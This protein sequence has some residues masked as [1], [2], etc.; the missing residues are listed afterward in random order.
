MTRAG[1]VF[2]LPFLGGL[3]M[4][5]WC[6][7]EPV[8]WNGRG[9]DDTWSNESN[10]IDGALPANNGTSDVL[11]VGNEGLTPLVDVDWSINSLAFDGLARTFTINGFPL[12][13]G[14]GGIVNNSDRPQIVNSPINLS[15]AQTWDAAGGR[16]SFG[17]AINNQGHAMTVGG[18]FDTAIRSTISNGGGLIKN[19]SGT[20]TLG[21]GAGDTFAN[22]YSGVTSV[23]GGGLLLNKAAG[24]ITIPGDLIVN[25]GMVITTASG[26]ISTSSNVTLNGGS[27]HFG[28]SNT[29]GTFTGNGSSYTSSDQTLTLTS[30][31][32]YVLTLRQ[33]G[34]YPNEF[35]K[36]TGASGG[37][38]FV[39]YTGFISAGIPGLDLGA[40]D[41]VINTQGSLFIG[42][43][44]VVAGGGGIIKTG[45]DTLYIS[46]P[47]AADNTYAGGTTINEGTI[48]VYD[49]GCLGN[50]VAPLTLNGGRLLV[51]S[52][53]AV[54][55]NRPVSI[56]AAGGTFDGGG[57][58]TLSAGRTGH[59]GL[60]GS[61]PITKNGTGT[62]TLGDPNEA[63]NRVPNTYNGT[64]TVN[65]GTL[66]L[67]NDPFLALAGGSINVLNSGSLDLDRISASNSDILF[68]SY[69]SL[70][71]FSS[72][73]VH[74]FTLLK[75]A[76]LLGNT[77]IL[78]AFTLGSGVNPSAVVYFKDGDGGITLLDNGPDPST[79][80]LSIDLGNVQ[81][82]FDVADNLPATD[83][84]INSVISNGGVRKIGPGTL[85]LIGVNDY[86]GGTAI[87]GGTVLIAA[88]SGLGEAGSPLTLDAGVLRASS[89]FVL[90]HP[91]TSN[92]GG[93]NV[94]AG[95]TL[96]VVPVVEGRALTKLGSGTLVL[97]N[98]T[99]ND[100]L[101]IDEGTVAMAGRKA[102]HFN[103]LHIAGQIES[104]VGILDLQSSSMV[105][106][107][108]DLREITDQIASGLRRGTGI[109]ST[110]R[111]AP[112]RLGSM[113]NNNNGATDRIYKTFEGIEGLNGDEVLV[114]YTFIGDLNLDGAVTISDFI[115]LAAHFNTLGGA[116]WQTGDVNYDGS[117]TIADFIDLS[118]NFGQSLSGIATPIS[119]QDRETLASFAAANGVVPEPVVLGFIPATLLLMLGRRYNRS[120]M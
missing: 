79:M 97:A 44:G 21:S 100:S 96:T 49:D 99:F 103:S 24:T 84:T 50:P 69:G 15:S 10:W 64:I 26:Q 41:R 32:P 71:L 37:G 72:L 9:A 14:T 86:N 114:R 78:N 80:N 101:T 3:L 30:T 18:G 40:V 59:G 52:Q 16:A 7:A 109:I 42:Y 13:I 106:E 25:G 65:N 111:G 34:N 118:S 55:S 76:P 23:N 70:T 67:R 87:N 83:L 98:N 29:I 115:D 46:R 38:V 88:D 63:N 58:I 74:S 48:S 43:P 61:G 39:G 75:D 68:D 116:T 53:E 110:A 28:D 92:D 94:D 102:L 11:F 95:A 89:S 33:D 31:A 6:A 93:I 57:N 81:R 1:Y 119:Q 117:V 17:G 62:L 105:L 66:M 8:T 4:V 104:W 54:S 85:A 107:R 36:L 2:V 47:F 77:L 56:G 120:C 12:S 45:P 82:D 20:L 73:S 91:V 22:S 19:G 112:Y 60:S 27:T 108:G 90:S 113:S 35:F 51:P 5:G